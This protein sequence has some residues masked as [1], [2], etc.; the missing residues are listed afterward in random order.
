[1]KLFKFRL[2]TDYAFLIFISVV[3]GI[4]FLLSGS[5]RLSALLSGLFIYI[6]LRILY[7]TWSIV[8]K[9]YERIVK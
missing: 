7:F 3:T 1:M 5:G 9:L 4:L 2:N 8:L 6:Y